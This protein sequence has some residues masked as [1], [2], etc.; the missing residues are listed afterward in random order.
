MSRYFTRV[1]LISSVVLSGCGGRI[2]DE[3]SDIGGSNNG[4]APTAFDT[5][6]GGAH[7]STSPGSGSSPIITPT[8]SGGATFVS[9]VYTTTA[10][11]GAN[12]VSTW[13]ATTAT[14]GANY[15]STWY[16]TTAS[17]GVS[18][19]STAYT[20]IVSGGAS[21]TSY[22]TTPSCST[23]TNFI[24]LAQ[25]GYGGG[26][27]ANWV[28]GDPTLSTDDPCGV[29]GSIYA[30]SDMGLDDLPGTADDTL[31]SPPR[32]PRSA[33]AEARVSPCA[34]GA[35]CIKG[36]TNRWPST[37]SGAV[38]YTASV[39]G[40]GMGMALSDRTATLGAK[41]LYRGPIRGF[42]ITLSGQLNAQVVRIGYS[43]FL[44]EDTAPYR[45]YSKLGSYTVLFDQVT[46]PPWAQ[47]CG[48]SDSGTDLQI[49]VVG[50]DV[51]GD[52]ALCVESITPI[53]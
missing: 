29:Q 26:S 30:F 41:A 37:S 23:T 4:G 44:G 16:T 10:T 42:T 7:A 33:D 31:Q 27:S 43:Q 39:W 13:Y 47:S 3:P 38:D 40:A 24:A 51:A 1:A 12:Y 50:G 21:S 49:L 14:G 6:I 15:A 11:G 19:L 35:C 2:E 32:D 28:G 52:F 48:W 46:C 45:E 8:P 5:S 53:L 22:V 20:T 34:N 9:S 25:R 17:G 18:Y 36:R